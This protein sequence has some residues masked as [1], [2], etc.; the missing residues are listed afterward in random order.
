MSNLAT[1]EQLDE[2]LTLLKAQSSSL[3]KTKNLLTS[4][5]ARIET[6]EKEVKTL[7]TT[8]TVLGREVTDLKDQLNARNQA[9]RACSLRVFG[10]AVT[11]DEIG[12]TDGGD[13]LK[14]RLYDRVL[15]PVLAAAKTAGD[16]PTV[17]HAGT[18]VLSVYRAGRAKVGVT[19][20]PLVVRLSSSELK[21]ALLRHKRRNLP[22]V[23]DAESSCGI[24]RFSIA[25][26]LTAA[27]YNKLRDLQRQ[28]TV[29]RAWTIDGR[30]R[31][32]LTDDPSTVRRVKS[33]F[34]A[35]ADI[36]NL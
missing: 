21:V 18:G 13:G 6:L 30:I 31:Y 7:K 15:K 19:P 9:D 5:L 32:T 4:S 22:P 33:V 2:V 11:P 26:D 20:P 28:E 25:E 10:V 16:I 36:L 24:Q 17:P 12:A 1:K 34:A 14:K 35:T 8:A 23:T 3:T 29:G 27:T